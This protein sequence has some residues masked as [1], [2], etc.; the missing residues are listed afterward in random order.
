MNHHRSFDLAELQ[1]DNSNQ[2][3]RISRLRTA[4][5]PP[6]DDADDADEEDEEE[7]EVCGK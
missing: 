2:W 6:F 7:V 4:A 3:K 1:K 5:P